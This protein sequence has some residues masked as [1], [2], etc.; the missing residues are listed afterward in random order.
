MGSG[1]KERQYYYRWN[2]PQI[3][4][5]FRNRDEDWDCEAGINKNPSHPSPGF[6]KLGT[7]SF[8]AA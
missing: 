6:V 5:T 8:D 7:A 2:H 3:N 1:S 4:I